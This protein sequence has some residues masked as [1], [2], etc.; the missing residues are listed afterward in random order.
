[1]TKVNFTHSIDGIGD[2]SMAIPEKIK[3]SSYNSLHGFLKSI[4]LFKDCDPGVVDDLLAGS[5]L[6]HYPKGKLLFIYGDNAKRY[7]IIKEGWVK[8]FRETLD[9]MQAVIDIIPKQS[10]FGERA[11]FEGGIYPFSAEVVEPSV[12]LSLSLDRLGKRIADNPR[13]SR[14]MLESIAS[15]RGNLEREIEHRLLQS[16]PQRIGCF[17]L[18][19]I[20]KKS[21][22]GK[23]EPVV[24]KLP[25][26]K[27]LI[28]ARL[29]MQPET[30]S[31]SLAKLK[32]ATG[33]KVRGSVVEFD[34]LRQITEYTCHACTSKYPC[35]RSPQ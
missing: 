30:F 5:H 33:I 15:Y 7:Y 19:F 1:M 3:I 6:E 23:N 26:D 4:P 20:E 2:I 27:T 14:S 9:G 16:A 28:A 31:R 13:L 35:Y 32:K 17:I 22:N 11:L 12:I 18:Q 24:I 8:L 10:L 21:A 34:E 25:Y 29:G